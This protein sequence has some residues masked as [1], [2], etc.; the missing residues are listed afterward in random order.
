MQQVFGGGVGLK[1]P[2]KASIATAAIALATNLPQV[3]ARRA[4]IS[5]KNLLEFK[6]VVQHVVCVDSILGSVL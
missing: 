1:P 5:I 2:I 4:K 3:R 6:S